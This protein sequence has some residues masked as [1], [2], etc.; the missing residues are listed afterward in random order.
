MIHMTKKH[1]N[2]SM[3]NNEYF[4]IK[5]KTIRNISSKCESFWGHFF[6][7]KNCCCKLWI[8][9][10]IIWKWTTTLNVL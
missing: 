2:I 5:M 4:E 8:L 6:Q 9:W 7:W 3:N 1:W 10:Q